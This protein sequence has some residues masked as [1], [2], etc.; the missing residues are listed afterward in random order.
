MYCKVSGKQGSKIYLYNTL[1]NYEYMEILSSNRPIDVVR[2]SQLDNIIYG[3][4][5]NG[6]Y[7]WSL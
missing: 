3:V 5:Q 2:F 4:H 7:F 6:Y 1:N